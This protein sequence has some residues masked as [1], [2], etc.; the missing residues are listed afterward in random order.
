MHLQKKEIGSISGF[1]PIERLYDGSFN[2]HW[3][4]A[5]G[6]GSTDDRAAIQGAIDLAEGVIAVGRSVFIPTPED[7]YRITST[8]PIETAVG[9]LMQNH[10]VRYH[11]EWVADTH[12]A[13]HIKCYFSSMQDAGLY[14]KGTNFGLI[15][16]RFSIFADKATHV[17]HM[18]TVPSLTMRQCR[19]TSDTTTANLANTPDVGLRI[20]QTFVTKLSGVYATGKI[21][22]QI[23][24]HVG[25]LESTSIT[26]DSC[27][28]S[29]KNVVYSVLNACAADGTDGTGSWPISPLAFE[30]DTCTGIT[31]N[32]CGCEVHTKALKA[33]TCL[34]F[35][36]NGLFATSV[37][38]IDIGNAD[39]VLD[40]SGCSG[41][42]NGF[43]FTEGGSLFYKTPLHKI[44]AF[45]E[46]ERFSILDPDIKRID[47]FSDQSPGNRNV[48]FSS[49]SI[50]Y[51]TKTLTQASGNRIVIPII[52]QSDFSIPIMIR[53]H[54]LRAEATSVDPRA[55]SVDISLTA[56]TT[57]TNILT[58][59]EYGVTSVTA[60]SMNLII[61]LDNII[62]AVVFSIDTMSY[63]VIENTRPQLVDMDN[64]T[65]IT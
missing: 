26:L 23:G 20:D 9:L 4:G 44:R 61:T 62:N 34:Q 59:N 10:N 5:V 58:N 63:G 64:I 27:Y 16:E 18:E 35:T 7:H 41:S 40:I 37:G 25:S 54:G 24:D 15:F 51:R 39:Y 65:F 22:A 46:T 60:S 36:I 50:Q 11:G 14:V 31:M 56:L 21:S 19:F 1:H 52:S 43:K 3:F 53:I 45:S 33:T 2:I 57:I 13:A 30:F 48:S 28:G 12:E 42:I 8:H 32:G 49:D 6:D 47:T 55:F 38:A 17:A 29:F